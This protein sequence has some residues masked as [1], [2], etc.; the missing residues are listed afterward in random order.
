MTRPSKIN[1]T[2]N[3]EQHEIAK[4]L[5]KNVLYVKLTSLT[6]FNQFEFSKSINLK[7]TINPFEVAETNYP[8]VRTKELFSLEY[9]K[10][11]PEEKREPGDYPVVGSNG[12]TGYHN[13]FLI[14]KPAIILGRKGSAGKVNY[15]EENCFP[16]DTTFYIVNKSEYPL[17]YIYYLLLVLPLEDLSKSMGVPGLNRN[18]VY[19]LKVPLI[20]DKIVESKIKKL[21]QI[22]AKQTKR[23]DP[24]KKASENEKEFLEYFKAKVISSFS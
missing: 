1:K 11:L 18:D 13:N 17:K 7:I 15:L 2:F 12:I 5:S 24:R 8:L 23:F 3:N 4:A 21:E 14:E 16:I 6:K 19:M 10:A 9:G 20:D 22:Y